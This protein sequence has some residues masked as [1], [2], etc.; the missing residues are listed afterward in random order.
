VLVLNGFLGVILGRWRYDHARKRV[1]FG[2]GR[3]NGC[4]LGKYTSGKLSFIATYIY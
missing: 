4:G 1:C 3:C 2:G